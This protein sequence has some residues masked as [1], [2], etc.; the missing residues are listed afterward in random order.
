MTYGYTWLNA[1]AI[2]GFYDW[3]IRGNSI[4]D[5]DVSLGGDSCYGT[6]QVAA[7]WQLYKVIGSRIKMTVVNLDATNPVNVILIPNCSSASYAAAQQDGLL[8]HPRAKNVMVDRY[9]GAKKLSSTMTTVQAFAVKDVDDVG[10]SSAFNA[11]PSHLWYWHI[12][13]YNNAGVAS[14]CEMRMEVWYDTI[15]TEPYP[16]NV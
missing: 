14:N 12:I 11:N 15:L 8:N 2:P 16:M 6:D 9:D 5:P 1:T 7:C 10:F 4:Y 3:V 13:S